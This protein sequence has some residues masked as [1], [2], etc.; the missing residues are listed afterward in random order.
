MTEDEKFD[1]A[2]SKAEAMGLIRCEGEQIFLLEECT[3]IAFLLH[4]LVDA[5]DES[6]G[7]S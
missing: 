2:V 6:E 1:A 4:S 5:L 7:K 3:D